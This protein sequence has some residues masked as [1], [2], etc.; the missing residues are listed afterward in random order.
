M[1]ARETAE[2][3]LSK[4]V[5]RLKERGIVIPTYAQMRDP[6]LV[7]EGIRRR[8]GEVGLWDLDPWRL[9]MSGRAIQEASGLVVHSRFARREAWKVRPELPVAV[10]PH[11]ALAPDGFPAKEVARANLGIPEGRLV[12]CSTGFVVPAKRLDAV[13]V[14]EADAG[15]KRIPTAQ[16]A[17]LIK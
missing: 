5:G 9:P 11:A 6:S 12:L 10:I 2:R 16:I 17:K 14:S 4:T 8:L 7:P 15:I 1:A 13:L 3:I